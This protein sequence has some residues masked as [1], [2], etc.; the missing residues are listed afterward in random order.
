MNSKKTKNCWKKERYSKHHAWQISDGYTVLATITDRVHDDYASKIADL[1]AAAPELLEACK[2]AY[3]WMSI[4]PRG[5]DQWERVQTL[6]D[7]IRK[8][9]GGGE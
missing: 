4:C 3:D 7:A 1:I 6:K 9:E 8:A 2:E 5:T